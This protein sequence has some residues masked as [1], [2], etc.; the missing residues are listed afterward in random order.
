MLDEVAREIL[1][2]S[3]AVRPIADVGLDLKSIFA[4]DEEAGKK[5]QGRSGN[6]RGKAF[7]AKWQAA[8]ESSDS[9]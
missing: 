5:T 2:F 1:Y 6:V 7:S 9:R 4:G 8:R 3:A